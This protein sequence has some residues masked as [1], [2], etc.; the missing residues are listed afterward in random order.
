MTH[1]SAENPD[2]NYLLTRVNFH[3]YIILN[4][5]CVA[6]SLSLI[7]ASNSIIQADLENTHYVGQVF[8][9]MSHSQRRIERESVLLDVKWFHRKLDIN[10]HHWVQ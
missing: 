9:I 3:N 4:G 2:P 1:A 7:K 8:A 5:R 6:P 10:L